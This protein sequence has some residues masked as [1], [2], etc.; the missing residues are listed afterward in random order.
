MKH[1]VTHSGTLHSKHPAYCLIE[2]RDGCTYFA[3]RTVFDASAF[4]RW[5]YAGI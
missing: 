1:T 3:H 4:A 5:H 2:D